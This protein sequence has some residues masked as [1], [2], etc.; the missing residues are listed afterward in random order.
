MRLQDSRYIIGIYETF[1]EPLHPSLQVTCHVKEHTAIQLQ[2]EANISGNKI[3]QCTLVFMLLYSAGTRK[4]S[5]KGGGWIFFNKKFSK[6][7][8]G[9]KEQKMYL[10]TFA[11]TRLSP[12]LEIWP[13]TP[14][15]LF[16]RLLVKNVVFSSILVSQLWV[17]H[18]LC[19]RNNVGDVS[20]NR[21]QGL[22]FPISPMR[23]LK[24]KIWW[25]GKVIK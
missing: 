25:T 17:S 21:K 10:K 4:T 19:T 7:Q 13:Y 8:N 1:P 20:M 14:L 16:G 23:W 3:V 6:W 5:L 15:A 11:Y 9:V 22:H 24:L 12:L 2:P 18:G